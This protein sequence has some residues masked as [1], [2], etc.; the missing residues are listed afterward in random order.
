MQQY[1][2][3]LLEFDKNLI[4]KSINKTI[5]CGQ[6]GYVCVV[7]GNVLATAT[8]KIEYREIVNNALVNICDGSSIALLAGIIHKE[9][10]LS[11]T[12]PDI[13]FK[14][15][16]KSIKQY[17][18]GNTM[19]NLNELR[20]KFAALDYDTSLFQFESLPFQ[21]VEQFEYEK[22]ATKINDFKPDIIWVSLGAPK[23]EVFISKLYLYINQGVLFAIGAAFNLFLDND[24]NRRA[25]LW[26]R[27]IHLEWVYRLLKEPNK[28]WKRVINYVF[29]LPKLVITEIKNTNKKILVTLLFKYII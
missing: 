14:Y 5:D 29:L 18:L 2:N 28:A 4:H 13:F 23:Q 24:R 9:K 26:M 22:I 3:I 19:D 25:P 6:K 11:Y 12:G 1:F 15:I 7:D 8:K 27:K 21:G 20:N 17:F 16:Q 10:L